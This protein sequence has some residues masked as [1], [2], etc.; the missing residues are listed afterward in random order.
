MGVRRGNVV[1]CGV[2]VVV[3][4][5]R[6]HCLGV[7][8]INELDEVSGVDAIVMLCVTSTIILPINAAYLLYKI[9]EAVANMSDSPLGLIWVR[10]LNAQ[11][12]VCS[13]QTC[14][15]HTEWRAA[16]VVQTCVVAELY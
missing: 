6:S 13:S 15:R 12:S 2:D 14:D 10:L 7:Y 16:Y 1:F 9:Q 8:V 4:D 5:M 11:C 3:L